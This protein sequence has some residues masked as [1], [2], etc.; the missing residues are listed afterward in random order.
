LKFNNEVSKIF[1]LTRLAKSPHLKQLLFREEMESTNQ[2][3]LGLLESSELALPALILCDSQTAGRGRGANQWESGTGSL[4]FSL[5]LPS[6]QDSEIPITLLSLASGWSIRETILSF[7]PELDVKIKWPND[8]LI[9]NQKVAGVLIQTN[10]KGV[11]VGAGVNLNNKVKLETATS[12]ASELQND[13]HHTDFLERLLERLFESFELARV[14]SEEF[15]S[16]CED[17]IAWIGQTIQ[18][19]CSGKRI[20]GTFLGLDRNGGIR[21]RDKLE[22]KFIY[23]ASD[24]RNLEPEN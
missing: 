7:A 16:A 8:V 14:N 17:S 12:L 4:T 2:I 24:I 6:A 9:G 3:G 13:I 1:V 22:T 23:S 15:L 10:T 21:L 18:M 20:S 19:N 11:V 5:L